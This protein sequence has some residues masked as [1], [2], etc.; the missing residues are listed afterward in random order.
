MAIAVIVIGWAAS[1]LY[2][3]PDRLQHIEI[4]VARIVE[5]Q[6]HSDS[7]LDSHDNDIDRILEQIS[8]MKDEVRET[9][10]NSKYLKDRWDS[11]EEAVRS[12]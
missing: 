7:R 1:L 6:E 3:I 11:W 9:A 2:R 12:E 8:Q 10:Y 4:V 5:H